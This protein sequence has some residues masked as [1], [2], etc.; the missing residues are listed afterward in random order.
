MKILENIFN[1]KVRI[2]N[3]KNSPGYTNFKTNPEARLQIFMNLILIDHPPP[4]LEY[5]WL[6]YRHFFIDII[7][8]N[9]NKY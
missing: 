1:W 7:L 9:V 6:P 4:H 5:A 8:K 3:I 2:N